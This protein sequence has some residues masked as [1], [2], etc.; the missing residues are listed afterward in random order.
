[1]CRAAGQLPLQRWQL[2]SWSANS[3]H[4]ALAMLTMWCSRISNIRALPAPD[5]SGLT[6]V[7]AAGCVAVEAFGLRASPE[8]QHL[9]IRL[10]GHSLRQA[11]ELS[12]RFFVQTAICLL[13]LV[14]QTPGAWWLVL[15]PVT[16]Q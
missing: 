13:L 10:G 7:L 11:T 4:H 3:H 9:L 14:K 12:T 1:M 16:G 6:H 2:K 15:L 8:E 5:A